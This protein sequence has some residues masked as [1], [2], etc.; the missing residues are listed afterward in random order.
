MA[1]CAERCHGNTYTLP[2]KM[3]K[4]EDC[5]EVEAC[6]YFFIYLKKKNMGVI[7]CGSLML[8]CCTCVVDV[9]CLL[10]SLC[11]EALYSAITIPVQ[12]LGI[13]SHIVCLA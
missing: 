11:N 10:Q 4:S 2:T 7:F 8:S 9:A 3:K 5:L 1:A 12:I 6:F 13:K